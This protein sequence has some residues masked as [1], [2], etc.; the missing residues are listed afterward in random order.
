MELNESLAKVDN[1]LDATVKRIEK[2]ANELIPQD[3]MIEISQSQKCRNLL[4]L[5]TNL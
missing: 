4:S 3:L 5:N 2:Q 1:T